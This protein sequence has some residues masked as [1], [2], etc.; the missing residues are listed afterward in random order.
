M[1]NQYGPTEAAIDAAYWPCKP[2]ES[3]TVPIGR[4]IANMQ[5]YVLNAHLQPVPVGIPGEIC[6]GGIGLA[7]GYLNRPDLTAEKFVPHPFGDAPGARLYRSGDLGRFLAEGNIEYLGRL[8][9]QVKVRGFRIELGEIETILR[10]H[11]A[12]KEAVV[13]AR[14]G[15]AG[16]K[17]LMA[18][19]VAPDAPTVSD[20]RG[21]LRTKL[22]EYMVPSV[23]VPL[24]ALPLTTTGKIDRRALPAP[25]QTRP[26]LDQAYVPPGTP[27][28]AILA[29]IWAGV[30]DAER[31]GINDN[32]FDLGGD[33]IQSIKIA[34]K[35]NQAGV[36]ITVRQ[37]FEHQT[38]AELAASVDGAL[39]A[40]AT[41]AKTD[42]L[43]DVSG[44]A[45]IRIAEPP[46]GTVTAVPSPM[47][48]SAVSSMAG[49]PPIS[50]GQRTL[51]V[52][53]ER[54]VGYGRKQ[55]ILACLIPD[56]D[57]FRRWYCG[58]CVQVLA[59]IEQDMV[60]DYVN[61]L[62]D[63]LFEHAHIGVGALIDLD[64]IVR[65]T[66]AM[67]DRGFYVVFRPGCG[68]VD[69]YLIHGCEPDDERLSCVIETR[70]GVAQASLA[71][72][73]FRGKFQ[74]TWLRHEQRGTLMKE[75]VLDLYR[76]RDRRKDG[77]PVSGHE[78]FL[79]QLHAY[80][81]PKQSCHAGFYYGIGVYGGLARRIEDSPGE[82]GP[83]LQAIGFLTEHKEAVHERIECMA[84][85][86][87]DGSRVADLA[88]D[89]LALV[90]DFRAMHGELSAPTAAGDANLIRRAADF[91]RMA[92]ERERRIL[93]DVFVELQR[94]RG[95]EAEQTRVLPVTLQ[96]KIT[97]WV[98]ESMPLC[99]VLTYDRFYPW[100]CS[101]FIQIGARTD[102]MGYLI[103][104][105][106]ENP[107]YLEEVLHSIWLTY[108]IMQYEQDIIRFTL[109]K[110]DVG[111][112]LR[113]LLDEYYL[114]GKKNYQK[115]HFVHSNLIYGYDRKE[116]KLLAIGFDANHTFTTIAFGFDEFARA[117][118]AGKYYDHAK[119]AESFW[120]DRLL[121][122][123][124][125][126]R[127]YI[128]EYPFEPRVFLGKLHDYVHSVGQETKLLQWSPTAAR[129]GIERVSYGLG[130]YEDI[131]H[132]LRHLRA[133]ITTTDFKALHIMAE[134]KRGLH[135][136]LRFVAHR[137]DLAGLAGLAD[138]YL[139]LAGQ[140]DTIRKLFAK[141]MFKKAE[142][143]ILDEISARVEKAG[144]EERALANKT[145]ARLRMEL[146]D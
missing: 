120:T 130:V 28:E 59:V 76:P 119:Y 97:T 16:E 131:V 83:F 24:E 9:D 5:L 37:I 129:E 80:L 19:V 46:A 86:D 132:H 53:T 52:N 42:P 137:Y 25:E 134:H 104:S 136:R 51:A 141:W 10:G 144:I 56:D 115:T 58:S 85:Y 78:E 61:P 77:E 113:M 75:P 47:S 68:E 122:R 33:S 36:A 45:T 125:M 96:H 17:R 22:P 94:T 14:E 30:L 48:V 105:Y 1:Y 139:A 6:I 127:D 118:E 116:R 55:S 60:L 11:P 95:Y 101:Q 111:Y 126:P 91:L 62:L 43:V 63:E 84:A 15:E 39:L 135:E 92:E 112:Y 8:D 49:K 18:Y 69:G 27:A 31:V 142:G 82:I 67:V 71:Y 110:L 99:I 65:Y 107:G 41:A 123:L 124:Y 100:F 140:F 138:G 26:A 34:A 108:E 89:Y 117:Y 74:E 3:R 93:L 57:L 109:E 7:R 64:D 133:G 81:F 40:D 102:S 50:A 32:F 114:P 20:L 73:E 121:V 98:T 87:R 143:A 38:I 70:Q 72:G 66:V 79:R 44:L 21:Y 2:G 106:H 23:F 145:Y 88:T 54:T 146:G 4:P 35:A 13:A 90:E 29:D 103:L 12:I 128:V